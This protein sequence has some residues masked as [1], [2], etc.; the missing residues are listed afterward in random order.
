MLRWWC[1]LNGRH[2]S[3]RRHHRH[4]DR[5]PGDDDLPASRARPPGDQLSTPRRRRLQDGDLAGYR[6][7]G[8]RM[9]R[10]PSQAPRPHRHR[11]RPPLTRSE[12][13]V[14][15]AEAQPGDVPPRGARP[16]Q[17]RALC[18]GPATDPV[19][20]RRV[21]S[22]VARPP[23]RTRRAVRR[24][25][26]RDR[27]PRGR[28]TPRVLRDGICGRQRD[29]SP[30]RP[31]AVPELGDESAVARPPDRRRR[32]AQQPPRRPDLGKARS[33]S[34]RVRP[35]LVGGQTDDLARSR[36]GSRGGYQAAPRRDN[37]G[38][39]TLRCR[40]PARTRADLSSAGRRPFPWPC[41]SARR[42]RRSHRSGRATSRQPPR[43]STSSRLRPRGSHPRT[44]G[45]GR[46][47]G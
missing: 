45:A 26:R 46:G 25:G 27:T 4:D 24:A 36:R 7:Q 34:V 28:R 6:D 35:R 33:S 22:I 41:R 29:R 14:D 42:H 23:P 39:H 10:R 1:D 40:R 17:H 37:A 20:S 43:R 2:R 44:S 31:P 11:T 21:R 32:S 16:A 13:L 30:L 19:G 5:E 47:T 12:R 8:P 9:G 3:R 15:G 38:R 18:A